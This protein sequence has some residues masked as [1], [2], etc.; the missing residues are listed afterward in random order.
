MPDISERLRAM[1]FIGKLDFKRYNGMLTSMRNCACQNLPGSYPK[2]LSA[3]TWTRDGLLVPL[4]RDSHSAF[5]A[6]TAFV[7]TKG[8]DSKASKQAGEKKEKSSSP[9]SDKHCYCCGKTGHIG[10]DCRFR[11]GPISDVALMV[12]KL[13]PDDDDDRD[14][15]LGD[16]VE[17]AAYITKEETVLLS[18]NDVVFDNGS[19]IHLIKNSKLL[20][21][22]S[23]TK[24]PIVVNGVQ[25]DAAGVRVN[26][27][28]K[29]GQ[30]ITAKMRQ[31]T[32]YPCPT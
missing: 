11:K 20:T 5:L 14:H 26:M 27:E 24:N 1:D 15:F 3:S 23:T 4:G 19:T 17:E 28:G 21:H 7:L 13:E 31:R 30:F 9:T 6:D 10:R 16:V 22:I 29:M 2:T 8:K 25:S 32:S 18:I 12:S